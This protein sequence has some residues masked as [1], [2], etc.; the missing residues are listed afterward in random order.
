[1]SK[2]DTDR[3]ADIFGNE[4]KIGDIV[5]VPSSRQELEVAKVTKIT[6]KSV[7]VCEYN[8]EASSWDRLVPI[9]GVIVVQGEDALAYVLS[10]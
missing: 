6:P 8:E 1:M 3:H 5:V 4:I 7:R 10:H 2:T 9:R